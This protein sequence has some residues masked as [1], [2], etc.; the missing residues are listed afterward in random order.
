SDGMRDALTLFPPDLNTG[1]GAANRSYGIECGPEPYESP[2]VPLTP[3]PES[4]V[5]ATIID[6]VAPP[7]EWG[8]PTQ[9]ALAGIVTQAERLL[10]DE[11]GAEV[12]IVMV[13]DREP[14][15]CDASENS[16][17]GTVAISE[18]AAD[19]VPT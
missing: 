3:L 13:T 7:N 6:G 4:E 9:P 1:D 12:V 19:R 18:D 10:V 11:P 16:V 5:F 15:Q 17:A 14:A 8:T 2:Q